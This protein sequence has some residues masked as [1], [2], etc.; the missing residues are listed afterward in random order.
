MLNFSFATVQSKA[1]ARQILFITLYLPLANI[2]NKIRD[3]KSYK[4]CCLNHH[5]ITDRGKHFEQCEVPCF[6]EKYMY[7]I[8]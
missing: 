4:I 8:Y 2:N 5:G 1:S 6:V 3:A 7:I